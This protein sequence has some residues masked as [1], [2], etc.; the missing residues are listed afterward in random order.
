MYSNWAGSLPLSAPIAILLFCSLYFNCHN[1]LSNI[2]MF[3]WTITWFKKHVKLCM[4]VQHK[5]KSLK[6]W[7]KELIQ[8]MKWLFFAIF[9]WWQNAA[10]GDE[11]LSDYRNVL[12]KEHSNSNPPFLTCPA[13][14]YQ[15]N[16]VCCGLLLWFIFHDLD[17]ANDRWMSLDMWIHQ[18]NSQELEIGGV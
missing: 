18:I 11:G 8:T 1:W 10:P 13:L 6:T 14:I 5:L 2:V 16:S 9:S 15:I 3:P 4:Q 12:V 17:L 7:Q